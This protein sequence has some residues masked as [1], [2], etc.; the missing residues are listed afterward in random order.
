MISQKYVKFV[1]IL[2]AILTLSATCTSKKKAVASTPTKEPVTINIIRE[3]LKKN[4]YLDME[5]ND[6]FSEKVFDT[7]LKSLDYYKLFLTQKD[8]ST[9]EKHKTEMDDYFLKNEYP[10]FEKSFTIINQRIAHAQDNYQD[11]LSK[12]FD[13]TIDETY[14]LDAEKVPY[15]KSTKELKDYWRKHLKED[16][17]SYIYHK[18]EDQK[19]AKEKSDTVEIK[20]IAV[21]ESEARAKILKDHNEWFKRLKSLTKDERFS[22]YINAHAAVFDPH[23][24]YFPPKQKEDFD[25]NISGRL[26]GIGATLQEKDGYIKVTRI[27]PGSA[28]WKQGEL[29]A[30]DVILKVGQAEAEAVDIVDMR[31]SDAVRLIRGKKGTEVR[32]TVR[33]LD[34]TEKII[35]IVRDIVVLEET[36]AKSIIVTDTVSGKRYGYINLPQFYVD[37]TGTGGRS[38]F[39]DIKKEIEKL[40]ADKI[41]GIVFDLR[42]NGGGSL[43]DVVKMSGLFIENGPIVQIK[44]RAGRPYVMRDN[45]PSV[46]YTGPLT[47]LINEQSASASEIFAA[48]IQD[49]KRGVIMGSPSSYGKGTVQTFDELD[50]YHNSKDLDELGTLKFT[51]SKFYRVNGGSTQWKGVEPDILLPDVYMLQEYGEKK[52]PHSIKWDEIPASVYTPWSIT[53]IDFGSLKENS[54]ARVEENETFK[55][56]K[57]NAMRYK[58][59]REET[60]V[61]LNYDKFVAEQQKREEEGE[62][63]KDLYKDKNLVKT[64]YLLKDQEIIA[65]DSTKLTSLEQLSKTISVDPYIKEAMNV[66]GEME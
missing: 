31:L 11:L 48:A 65:S 41:S 64:S 46:Q 8:V 52:L 49:Y 36:Y 9:L 2:I 1:A 44:A 54:N 22:A 50:R 4:H 37:F 5:I 10:I 35:P 7:Y 61:S 51:M 20:S 19:K 28:S 18:D 26:E 3:M 21:L 13:L 25:I 29:E 60:E 58:A 32:L 59:L 57:E 14:E 34:G 27:V 45:D 38:C 6:A 15:A 42:N 47:V 39:K 53:P 17:I 16:V 56:I 62:K 43:Q 24:N 40:Q 63:Y 66:L 23:T 55:L 12:P 30:E 33:K